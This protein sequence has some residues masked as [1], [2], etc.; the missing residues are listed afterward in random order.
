LT[1]VVTGATG[2]VG[3]LLARELAERGEPMRLLVTDP[4]RAPEL[5]GA[6]I[7]RCDYDDPGLLARGLKEGDRVFMVS[8]HQGPA[9]RL[10]MH[11]NFVDAAKQAGVE[12]VVYLSFLNAGPDTAFI[13]G[14]AHGETERMLQESGLR[15][16]AIRNSMYA[17]HIP[18]WFD[19]DGVA[20]ETVGDAR[21]S[22]SYRPELAKAIAV[23]LTEPGHDGVVNITTPDSVSFAEL[24]ELASEVTG[25]E[26]RYEPISHEEWDERWRRVG[27]DGWELEAGH[28]SYEAIRNGEYDLVTDDY[29]RLTGEE[30]LTIKQVLERHADE[31]PL[32]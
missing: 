23:T 14:K 6:E 10:P 9:R 22:F 28:T 24:A 32:R 5:P 7:A 29:E 4:A 30:P 11:R 20:R 1:I 3:G 25:K 2:H 26:Y 16:T 27:R 18:G 13:H 19:P 15:W 31:L 21:M 8:M 12:Q 17:D